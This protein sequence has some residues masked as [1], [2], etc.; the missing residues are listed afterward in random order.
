MPTDKW[1]DD[2]IETMLRDFPTIR[3]ERPKEE[4]YD[5]LVQIEP[6]K[7]QPKRWMP[8]LVAALAFLTLGVLAASLLGQNNLDTALDSENNAGS[9][10]AVTAVDEEGEE[11]A[12]SVTEDAVE[13]AEESGATEEADQPFTADAAPEYR[14]AVY[15]EDLEAYKL[16]TV[17]MTEN[18]FV[19]PVSFLIPLDKVTADLGQ[20]N[21]DSLD[22][23]LEY[24]AGID[25][26]ALG[27][28][29]YHP[30]SGSLGSNG[31]AIEHRLPEGHEYDMAS[32][33]IEVYTGSLKST[34]TDFKEIHVLDEKGGPI[35]F[36]QVGPMETISTYSEKFAFYAFN[37]EGDNTYLV[38]SYGMNFET[39]TD[40]VSEMA[41]SPSDFYQ[42]AIPDPS[43]YEVSETDEY[44]IIDFIEP[45][46]FNTQD[47][48]EATRMIESL[49]LTA[50]S[51]GKQVQI[52][53][54]TDNS[55][56][57]FDFSQP[58]PSP[59][60]ANRMDWE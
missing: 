51:F 58:I 8:I 18:A 55:W 6:V 46:D 48:A 7:K 52:H 38:P 43:T 27:F 45:Y 20:E 29:E 23:Y 10:S 49:A 31:E 32:A 50:G 44:L 5:K 28:D 19:V 42:P 37:S 2:R 13:P 14:T 26:V 16:F 25:E 33:A 15:S 53:N 34:F 12:A 39:A 59:V 24:A 3:D 22:L 9:D 40:A 17:G 47:Q 30:Y 1:E 4:V 54:T 36:N 35:E 41:T 57:G 60:A 56:N 21:P 11:N